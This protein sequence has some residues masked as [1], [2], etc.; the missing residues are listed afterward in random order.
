LRSELKANAIV[1][2]IYHGA[3]HSRGLAREEEQ[4][5]VLH[6]DRGLVR[7]CSGFCGEG[8]STRLGHRFAG[9]RVADLGTYSSVVCDQQVASLS[10]QEDDAFM[11]DW[12]RRR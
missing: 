10:A 6:R 1:P 11:I 5:N 9:H 3:S 8:P 4:T 2:C 12:N 7:M